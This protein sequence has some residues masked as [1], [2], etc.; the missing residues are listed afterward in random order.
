MRTR[1][2]FLAR[3]PQQS[4]SCAPRTRCHCCET[5]KCPP[6]ADGILSIY[7]AARRSLWG[8]L[9]SV[10]DVG[11]RLR[12]MRGRFHQWVHISTGAH[13][14]LDLCHDPPKFSIQSSLGSTKH[15][16]MRSRGPP[17][18]RS[19][20]ERVRG[21]IYIPKKSIC[22]TRWSPVPVKYAITRGPPVVAVAVSLDPI[23]PQR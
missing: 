20:P 23:L 11:K 8:R 14:P 5:R 12:R 22:R 17:D 7:T 9:G 16:R 1:L 13:Q 18:P 2:F 15:R 21:P 10:L 19:I 4:A 3:S 6:L